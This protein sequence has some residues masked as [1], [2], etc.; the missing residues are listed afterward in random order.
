M[1]PARWSRR[2]ARFIVFL[3]AVAALAG[4][5]ASVRLPV[6]LFPH[7]SFPRVRV[8]LEAGDQPAE[9]MSVEV[10]TPLEEAVRAV[11]GVRGVRS[12]TS[13]GS[14]QV[15]VDF[16]WGQDML[17]AMLQV[18][19]QVNRL[20]PAL[21]P[22]ATFT[23]ERMDP[24][25]FPS[26]A[27]SLTSDTRSLTELRDLASYEMRPALSA[28][29][30]VARIEVQG[31]DVEEFRVVADPAKLAAYGL[32]VNDLA[33]TVSA[34]NILNAVGRI[35]DHYKLYLVVTNSQF[36]KP[37][38]VES[39]VVRAGA[40]G[41]VR[42]GDVATVRRAPAP[43]FTRV[44]ADGHD[45]VLLLVFQQ[46]DGNTVQI[47]RDI[48]EKRGELHIPE[49]VKVA[50]WYDQSELIKASATSVAEATLIGVGLAGLVLL[51]FL[52][53][54]K[55]TLIATLAVPI[56]LA[57]TVLVLYALG[58]SFNVMT[59]G[60]MAAAVGLIIDD[61]IV[62]VEHIVRRLRGGGS[63]N[64]DATE[65]VI[66]A[67]DEFA[68][69]LTGSSAST[70]VIHIPP[71]FLI[72]VAGAFFAAL[73][74]TMAASLCISFAVAWLVI[75][76]LAARLLGPKDARQREGGPI[77]DAI[78]RA[79][80]RVMRPL[81]AFPWLVLLAIVPLVVC[82]WLAYARLPTGFMP[83][84]DEGG[85]IL[86]YIAPPG[87]SVAETN[88]LMRQIEA[89][90]RETPEVETYSRRTGLQLGGG[91]TESNTGDFFIRMKPFPRRDIEKV[92][93]EVRERVERTIPGLEIET[94][95]LM[96][97]L[98]GDLTAV[99][100][101]I[102]VK[103]FS[104][105]EDALLAAA[106]KVA[107]IVGKV[108]GMVEVKSGVV[109]AGDALE[110]TVDPVKVAL[111]GADPDAVSKSVADLLSGRVATQVLHGP[112]LIGV[113]AWVPA[114]GR[115][116]EQDV[117]NLTLRAPDGHLFPLSRVAT[118]KLVT[119]QPEI[120]REDLKRMV[121]VTGRIS[122][123]DLGSAARDVKA[124][125]HQPGTLPPGI[126]YRL[127]GLYQ[128][129]QVAFRGLVLVI[130][131]AALLVFLLLLLLYES[132]RVATA[133]LVVAA[134]SMAAVLVGLWLTGTELNITSIMGMVMIV[135]NVTEVGVFYYSEYAGLPA[136]VDGAAR[137]ISA[138]INRFRA[139]A[140]TTLAAI[141]ALMPLSLGIG[142]GS[143][144]LRPLGTAII[145]GLTVQLPLVLV[146]L[147]LLLVI[148]RRRRV[149]WPTHA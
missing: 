49:D 141:L 109:P 74:L 146:V 128:E 35:E 31:G 79:Y 129:Q 91:I 71:A 53:N 115:M 66:D 48:H 147:P 39:A 104:D 133:M 55:V 10:T 137:F 28:V 102:E 112:K 107:D 12:T 134:L 7:V 67:A 84:M 52:R 21:P 105:D 97:D 88:R 2:H 111:E 13:R 58:M 75:P 56:V 40:N 23:V 3:T 24:T 95:Q 44:T 27:Y 47:S 114:T 54:W 46:P 11:P 70:I 57:T 132:F 26:L 76:A 119:G 41:V 34:S 15:L 22:G 140:M 30:G 83:V 45:A 33:T 42:V 89:V 20:L 4:A 121:A 77:T 32:T 38:D 37:E 110:I 93:D 96:E 60:G 43:Q 29:T 124:V 80:G 130:A 148:M 136:D 120:T 94:M 144:M 123:R 82:G 6:A 65:R 87:T 100:Q 85:F 78:Q 69:P 19:S 135:G 149:S 143:A 8:A 9:R 50:N 106:P 139:I 25:V 86:D 18:D 118:T 138:G 68:R 72:G 122:G 59:L 5:A 101:P 63:E 73:S 14:A 145:I 108:D 17:A 142:H 113:R 64:V 98:I 127:G 131:A 92:M 81:L 116:S 126:S 36:T 51:L 103:L 117:S 1:S 61:A 125:L 62:M 90:L 99:P 16:D